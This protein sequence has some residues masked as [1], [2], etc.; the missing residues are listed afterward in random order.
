MIQIKTFDAFGIV[1]RTE[2]HAAVQGMELLGQE[3]AHPVDL[4]SKTEV[5]VENVWI[6]LDNTDSINKHVFDKAD[7]LPP[8]VVLSG[9]MNVVYSF[10]FGFLKQ[11]K[12]VK[13]PSRFQEE[14]ESID[15]IHTDPLIAA[16]IQEQAATLRELEE[17]YSLEDAFRIFDVIMAKAVNAAY[18]QD[19]AMRRKE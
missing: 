1:Y 7:A 2:Q 13:I 5:Q 14:S 16:L 3:N 15:S 8:R 6:K 4:L 19:A 12:G 18:A 10:N 11:W 9:L 17:Y